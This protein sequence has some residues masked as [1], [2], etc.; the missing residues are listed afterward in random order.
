METFTKLRREDFLVK[1]QKIKR[2][3]N[4]QNTSTP[5]QNTQNGTGCT[6]RH[7]VAICHRDTSRYIFTSPFHTYRPPHIP[8]HM[9]PA[10]QHRRLKRKRHTDILTKHYQGDCPRT[11]YSHTH[12][13]YI[14]HPILQNYSVF[15]YTIK[16][17]YD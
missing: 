11:N 9:P 17:S 6:Y 3:V 8:Q 4:L 14:V 13:L 16:L 10:R 7:T 1:S 12:I 5:K 15:I 2:Q